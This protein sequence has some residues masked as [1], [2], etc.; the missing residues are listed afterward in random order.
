LAKSGTPALALRLAEF[1]TASEMMRVKLK[2][3][4]HNQSLDL[5]WIRHDQEYQATWDQG[6]PPRDPRELVIEDPD[7]RH[8]PE[9]LSADLFD[10][11]LE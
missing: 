2:R 7:G 6:F 4:V 3:S 10:I 8:A 5:E 9:K 11:I 1:S